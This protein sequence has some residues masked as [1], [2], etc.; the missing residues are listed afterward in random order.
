VLLGT[1]VGFVLV[2]AFCGGA[3][4]LF[5]VGPGAALVLAAFT[6][7]WGGPGF[8][9]MMGFVLHESRSSDSAASQ[10]PRPGH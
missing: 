2:G 4:L 10:A 3:A 8:G 9:G 1:L 7:F 5:G 6:G